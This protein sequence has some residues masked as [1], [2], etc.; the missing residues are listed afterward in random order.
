[1]KARFGV[2][3]FYLN[4]ANAEQ[5]INDWEIGRC[6]VPSKGNMV[7]LPKM[8]L[9]IDE[10]L[11]TFE[12]ERGDFWTAKL[13]IGTILKRSGDTFYCVTKNGDELVICC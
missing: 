1:M 2:K 7:N 5:T 3:S 12:L 6:L 10:N 13:E 8:F 4:S 11:F 9:Q